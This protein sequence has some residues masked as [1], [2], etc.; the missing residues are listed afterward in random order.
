MDYQVV[1]FQLNP[2]GRKQFLRGVLLLPCYVVLQIGFSLADGSDFF[3]TIRTQL[4]SRGIRKVHMRLAE[5]IGAALH[6]CD[7]KKSD[8]GQPMH[9]SIEY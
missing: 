9:A 8:Q 5:D 2:H 7:I 6:L 1:F 4:D 3:R